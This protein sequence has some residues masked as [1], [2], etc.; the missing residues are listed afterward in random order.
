MAL[1]ARGYPILSSGPGSGG[2]GTFGTST[3]APRPYRIPTGIPVPTPSNDNVRRIGRSV[4]PSVRGFV[5]SRFP[6]LFVARQIAWYLRQSGE[7]LPTDV[8]TDGWTLACGSG[9]SGHLNRLGA[10]PPGPQ[11][12]A[13]ADWDW[14]VVTVSTSKTQVMNFFTNKGP[15]IDLGGT[16]YHWGDQTSRWTRSYAS[17]DELPLLI[18][19]VIP[20]RPIIPEIGIPPWYP[21]WD[22]N[23]VPIG[24]P[25]PTPAPI[26]YRYVPGRPAAPGHDN[27]P[28]RGPGSTPRVIPDPSMAINP[29]PTFVARYVP[30]RGRNQ[31]DVEKKRG[32]RTPPGP[33]RK[34]VHERK[35]ALTV[36]RSNV[37]R[38][39]G[40]IFGVGT[41]V[42]DWIDAFYDALPK[43][44]KPKIKAK[45]VGWD[46]RAKLVWKHRDELDWNKAWENL[47]LNEVEDRVIGK[48]AK[49]G[50]VLAQKTGR[51][52]GFTIGPAL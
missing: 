38:V 26:P 6:W 31:P 49:G 12:Q 44:V 34:R 37:G 50:K 42:I 2:T 18:P 23:Q 45:Y 16:P 47:V 43:R 28:N 11:L 30:G 46:T 40:R 15:E 21:H 41:E 51:N 32:R 36:N 52:A 22:P 17:D 33:P 3:G 10:C 7:L 24:Q 48:L 1:T 27:R 5:R 13:A 25:T 9:S 35:F 20:A 39:A 4:V 29:G 8:N 19:G 14:G